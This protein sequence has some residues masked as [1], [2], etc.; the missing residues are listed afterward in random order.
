MTASGVTSRPGDGVEG[1]VDGRAYRC[2]RRDWVREWAGS[3]PDVAAPDDA[4]VVTLTGRDGP[5]ASFVLADAIRP[6]SARL[7]ARLRDLGLR[8]TVL[9]GDREAPVRRIAQD[10]GIA[11]WRADARPADKRA[12]IEA[13]QR[14]G[15]TIAMIGDGINDA[16]ALAQADVSVA[17][18]QA[19]ALAQWTADIVVL[20]DDVGKVGNA[21]AMARRTFAV[22]RQNLGWAAAYNVIAIPLAV[23]GH[24]SPLAAAI[25]MSVSSLVVVANALRL[26]KA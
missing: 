2:G 4:I 13:R 3:L 17:L 22:I 9:S 15:A 19:S 14:E 24:V 23:T 18:G 8:V 1:T 25:G 6:G 11:H 16:P 7:G 20:G 26:M 10:A 21:F 5:L 12:F